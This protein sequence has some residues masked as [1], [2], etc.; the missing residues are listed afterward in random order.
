MTEPD[1]MACSDFGWT[2]GP[3]GMGCLFEQRK[4]LNQ[5][6]SNIGCY[7]GHLVEIK[8]FIHQEFLEQLGNEWCT[9]SV[10]A[11]WIGATDAD[12]EGYWYWGHSKEPLVYTN[13]NM[14]EPND[15]SGED[16]AEARFSGGRNLWWNDMPCEFTHLWSI[17]QIN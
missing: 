8:S 10:C 9:H 3:E 5:Q 16:C 12:S 2:Q 6:D 1:R 17:C 15:N 13:W 7:P 11:W 4:D 14:G